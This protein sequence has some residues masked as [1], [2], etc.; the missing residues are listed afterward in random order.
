MT[1]D[2]D[3]NDTENG[4]TNK[5][6]VVYA[7][8]TAA[9]NLKVH[10][11]WN[12]ISNPYMHNYYPGTLAENSGLW[13]GHWEEVNG[14]WVI[15]EDGTQNVPYLTFYDANINDYSQVRSDNTLIS[16]FNA[17]F[18]Q[19]AMNDMLLFSDPL[20]L[21]PR[22]IVARRMINEEQKT[23]V[24]T[25]IILEQTGGQIDQL[26]LV[27]GDKYTSGY[28]IGGDLEKRMNKTR[29]HTYAILENKL[30][31]CAIDKVTAALPIPVGVSV[32]QAGSYT[33][34]FDDWQYDRNALEALSLTDYEAHQTTNLLEENYTCNLDAGIYENR[35]AINAVLKEKEITT[36]IESVAKNGIYM[37]TNDNGSITICSNDKLT[38]MIVHDVAGRLIGR[39]T[40]NSYQWTMSLP[41]GVYAISIQSENN[42]ATVLKVC[43]K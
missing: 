30:A 17:A 15:A 19:V 16:P 26:G 39:W 43:T 20:E 11:G 1:P 42:G 6:T 41:Q 25:G 29:L 35:F 34:R 23:I 2:V 12:L 3:W 33:F 32:P 9:D 22:S 8:T 28:D 31:F 38:D 5:T 4:T 21:R 27:I 7:Q 14:K 40:P 10:T 24:N 13:N 36:D 37:L 18:V